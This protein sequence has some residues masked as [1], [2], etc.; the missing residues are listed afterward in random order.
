MNLWDKLL[1]QALIILNLLR[2]FHLNPAILAFAQ[3]YRAFNYDRAPL[4][5]SGTKVMVH[6]N[7]TTVKPAPLPPH[8]VEAWYTEVDLYQYWRYRFWVW[9]ILTECLCDTF[10]WLSTQFVMIVHSSATGIP[11]PPITYISTCTHPR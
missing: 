8:A 11:P 7:Q 2:R 10:A 4:A 6:E 3:V 1:P 5:P 9:G